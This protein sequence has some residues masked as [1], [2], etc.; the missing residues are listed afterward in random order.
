M[1]M[2]FARE[3]SLLRQRLQIKGSPTTAATLQQQFG[4]GQT[5]LGA[6][7][8]EASAAAE[9]LA[10]A[11]PQMGRAQMTA[12]V[13]TLWSSK[14]HDLRA[15]G[16]KLLVAR[17]GL[18]EPHDLPL[19]EQFLKDEATDGVQRQ[20]ADGVLGALVNKNKKLWKD[21]KRYATSGEQRQQRAA[22]RAC[23][24]PLV[25]DHE[26]FPRFVDL[27]LGLVGSPDVVLQAAIDEVLT[28][29]AETHYEAVRAFVA[30][31]ARRCALPK[32]KP[33]AAP[34][35]T[36]APQHI[37]PAAL[38]TPAPAP[39][40]VLQAAAAPAPAKAKKQ[41]VASP[42]KK[43]AAKPAAKKAATKTKSKPK[44]AKARAK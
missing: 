9:D 20:L 14:I 1:S 29:A 26:A 13:R 41:K 25:H 3:Q 10:K 44:V 34:R 8:A 40:A 22:V 6:N 18:L 23:R 12:F 37:A 24:L 11:H 27:V 7:D 31:H 15:V 32:P 21:L 16:A 2:N 42:A 43:A 35:P 28:A 39:V 33:K 17:A 19:L 30:Q 36:P 38:P 4:P 5:F